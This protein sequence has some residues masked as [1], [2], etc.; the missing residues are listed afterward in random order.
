MKKIFL[1][2]G[3]CL[4]FSFAKNSLSFNSMEG[5]CGDGW[6]E[7]IY[8]T[9]SDGTSSVPKIVITESNIRITHKIEGG[10]T[11]TT[12]HLKGTGGN[13]YLKPGDNSIPPGTYDHEVQGRIVNGGA[14]YSIICYK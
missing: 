13:F 5:S 1:L 7:S 6:K 11:I 12:T 8:Y 9:K 3:I 2:L 10:G 14:I 4:M